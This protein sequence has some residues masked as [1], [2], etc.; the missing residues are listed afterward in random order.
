M[1]EPRVTIARHR[2]EAESKW[3]VWLANTWHVNDRSNK[4]QFEPL[5]AL[6]QTNEIIIVYNY[7]VLARG[8]HSGSEATGINRNAFVINVTS[9]LTTSRIHSEQN[10]TQQSIGYCSCWFVS[11]VI[12]IIFLFFSSFLCS[13]FRVSMANL[14]N[15]SK[16]NHHIL[17]S[18]PPPFFFF[19]LSLPL[20][21]TWY[22][23]V[24]YTSI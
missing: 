21:L 17:I 12:S 13:A 22:L 2:I 19:R 8:M 7:R 14:D 20:S 4:N 16:W 9:K 1:W 11:S 10:A 23:Y 5:F 24:N 6:A 18:D 15:L 3:N